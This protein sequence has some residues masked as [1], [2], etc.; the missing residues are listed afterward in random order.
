MAGVFAASTAPFA[1][2]D[3]FRATTISTFFLLQLPLHIF[4]RL[5][6]LCILYR[7]M[8]SMAHTSFF[9]GSATSAEYLIGFAQSGY[10][11]LQKHH[12]M[13]YN[14]PALEIDAYNS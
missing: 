4:L 1:R 13:H 9:F 2:F 12:F 14:A 10:L 8:S 6:I 11:F 3:P 7:K 5:L